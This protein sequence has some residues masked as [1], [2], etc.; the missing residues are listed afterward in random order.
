MGNYKYRSG[1]EYKNDGIQSL[2]LEGKHVENQQTNYSW[3]F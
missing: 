2:K 1:K 3:S